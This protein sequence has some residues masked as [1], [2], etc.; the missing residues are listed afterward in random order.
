MLIGRA[1]LERLRTR[2]QAAFDGVVRD[3]AAPIYDLHCWLSGDPWLAEDLAQE[4]FLNAWRGIDG[5]RGQCK[6]S[7]WLYRI[8]RNVA[9]EHAR[10]RLPPTI[11]LE[12]MPEKSGDDC[13]SADAE[14]N[15]LRDQ[16]RAALLEIPQNQREAV[17]LN[18]LGGLS[19]TEVA[20][21]LQEPVG[22]VK[23]HIAQGIE[24]LHLIL[25]RKGVISREL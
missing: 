25:R 6:L 17:V 14:S 8:A 9:A 1:D 22:T 24:T 18:K 19:H 3:Y 12:Q 10:K 5:F 20:R 7:T 11:S 21:V 2:D 15:I 13:T 23:W 16:V 4:T